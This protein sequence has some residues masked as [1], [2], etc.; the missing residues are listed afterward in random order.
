MKFR[1]YLFFIV[2]IFNSCIGSLTTSVVPGMITQARL[3]MFGGDIVIYLLALTAIWRNKSFVGVHAFLL[4]L[5]SA[6]FSFIYNL[7]TTTPAAFLNGLREPLFFLGAV[8]IVWDLF[9]S[10]QREDFER[11]FTGFLLVFAIAQIPV[12]VAQ[13]VRF[14]ANDNVGG[15]YGLGGS[16]VLTQVLFLIS[17]YFLVRNG[18]REEGEEFSIPRIL[19]YSVFLIPAAI[20]ETKI[21][22]I[23]LPLYFGLLILTGRKVYRVIPIMMVAFLMGLLFDYYYST[24][25]QETHEVL[26]WSYV[27]KYLYSDP[28][29]EDLPRLARIPIMFRMMRGDIGRILLG[30]G[31]GLFAGAHLLG[32]TKIGRAV[33]FLSG[34][35]VLLFTLWIQGGLLAVLVFARATTWFMRGWTSLPFTIRRFRWF[36]LYSFALV[37]LY[38]DAFLHRGFGLIAAYMM[39]WVS[40]RGDD[41]EHPSDEEALQ[42]P[43]EERS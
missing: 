35:R 31:Y 34:S 38:N 30:L 21:S 23:L 10:E 40:T 9:Q 36:L 39:V 42:V 15:T 4:L 41:I 3:A 5:V 27:E 19:L 22:F 37:W 7:E 17:F 28:D 25:V 18:S 12:A 14:G 43:E 11:L 24:A 2:V 16:G 6:L 8:I 20:N 26:D 1:Q 29:E 13:F 32:T 33:A